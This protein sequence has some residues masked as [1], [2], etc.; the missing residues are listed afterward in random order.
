MAVL[1]GFTLPAMLLPA[2]VS[3]GDPVSLMPVDEIRVGQ[4]AV[5]LSVFQ[6]STP[7]TFFVDIIGILKNVGPGRD[8]ILGKARGE[9]L[10]NTGIIAGMSGSPVYIGGRLIGAAAYAWTF[11]KEPIVGIT[12]IGEMMSMVE[13]AGE[14]SDLGMRGEFPEAPFCIPGDD[15]RAASSEVRPIRT[16]VVLTGVPGSAR[17][18]WQ[19]FLSPFGFV[20]VEGGGT[21][22]QDAERTLRPGSAM[23]VQ[24]VRGDFAS[25]AI[26]TVTWVDGEKLLGFGHP[27]LLAGG[28]SLPLSAV[29]I[30]TVFPSLV[31]SFKIG[32][33]GPVVGA[34]RQDRQ[35]GVMGILGAEVPMLP[36]TVSVSSAGDGFTRDYHFEVL[37]SEILTSSLVG[38]VAYSSL[39]ASQ[40]GVGEATLD[41]HTQIFIEP[42]RVLET[43]I[44]TA[45]PSPP[46]ALADEI[47][48]P[49]Q[50]LIENPYEP[51]RVREIRV[52]VDV[53]DRFRVAA[54]EDLRVDRSRIRPG[55]DVQVRIALRP[56]RE[57][58]EV[59]RVTLH[60]PEDAPAGMVDLVACASSDLWELESKRAPLRFE[61]TS[62][63]QMIDLLGRRR[64]TRKVYI[65]LF[66]HKSGRVV[67]GEE[68]PGLPGSVLSVMSTAGRA[69]PT[70]P[71]EG[72]V[73]LEHDI[74]T[75]WVVVGSRSMK[76]EILPAQ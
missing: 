64:D 25:T 58:E 27:F 33:P 68:M 60:V 50:Y 48:R 31:S 19:E 44:A 23:G 46:L 59:R 41:I 12:P 72:M 55:E 37:R 1:A 70:G 73:L 28:V 65:Q 10:E 38:L 47:G 35:A 51:L 15:S 29:Y 63:D 26:G 34:I 53:V 16:P 5:G 69:G 7:D 52:H 32:S 8:L 56:Y 57:S 20:G 22:P 40:K 42:D 30:H 21:A 17:A 74:D 71:S 36:V 67:G 2:R 9:F 11:A 75:P 13:R 43:R 49:L 39:E 6:G 14:S 24:M 61:P 45:S 62:L 4:R 18:A 66:R 76:I 54:V 3:A